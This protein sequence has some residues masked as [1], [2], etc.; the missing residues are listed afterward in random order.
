MSVGGQPDHVTAVTHECNNRVT[1]G[2]S[3]LWWVR[4]EAISGE[5]TKPQEMINLFSHLRCAPHQ[6][7]S[8]SL[9]VTEVW[10]W[11][12]DEA[13]HKDWVADWSS[14]ITWLWLWLWLTLLWDSHPWQRYG[15]WRSPHCWKSLRRNAS[16][17]TENLV[18]AG[19]NC[20]VCNQ[21]NGYNH[22]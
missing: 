9:T 4:A 12:P 18:H 8:N 1:D 7:N 13:W 14:V 21:W 19:V 5:P 17:D 2:C 11:V 16:K 3:V 15:R 6:Q 22:L 20:K 10:S